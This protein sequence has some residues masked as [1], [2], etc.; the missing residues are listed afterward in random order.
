MASQLDTI[1]ETL[2]ERLLAGAVEPG[3]RL[4][5]VAL[6]RRLDTSRTLVR[7]AMA[8]LETEG[9]LVREPNRG[10]RVRTFTLEE[11]TD[12]IEVRGEMEAMAAR[13]TAERGLEPGLR[14]EMEHRLAD[15]EKLM[16]T[17][18]ERTEDRVAWIDC[19]AAFHRAL[20]TAARN[21]ALIDTI[22]HLSR[23][24]LAGPRAIVFD[25]INTDVN[26]RQ[27]QASNDDHR[28][29]FQ[30]VTNRQG[31]RAAALV[32]EHAYRSAQNKRDN[33]EAMKANRLGLRLPGLNL[34]T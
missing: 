26:L 30:A 25:Q 3:Q 8:T 21:Q 10:F 28:R 32:R 7:L 9:L 33:F 6:A 24:P 19:N 5:E 20:L 27:I 31:A 1:T 2:R 22:A 12:A 34:I 17:R 13:V 14:R 23:V 18:L 29:I 16:D 15:A 11:V 4:R